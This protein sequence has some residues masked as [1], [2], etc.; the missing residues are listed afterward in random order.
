MAGVESVKLL[1][2]NKPFDFN[3]VW[4]TSGKKGFMSGNNL[5]F[6]VAVFDVKPNGSEIKGFGVGKANEKGL[7]FEV[8]K[9]LSGRLVVDE[10]GA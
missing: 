6:V 1:F 7:L 10:R 2:V 4:T 3:E 5:V 9:L 8:L